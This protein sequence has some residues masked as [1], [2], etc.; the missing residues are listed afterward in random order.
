MSNEDK[1]HKNQSK[2]Y[3]VFD[4]ILAG[5]VFV[6]S[7][8]SGAAIATNNAN[9]VTNSSNEE[10]AKWTRVVGRWTRGLVIVGIITTAVL[11]VQAVILGNQFREM[12]I[13]QRPWVQPS[14]KGF[15]QIKITESS[16]S[17]GVKIELVNTGKSPAFYVFNI[18]EVK[19]GN[20]NLIQEHDKFCHEVELAGASSKNPLV[21]F[22]NKSTQLI[23]EYSTASRDEL[24]VNPNPKS[25]PAGEPFLAPEMLG[26]IVYRAQDE[27]A[28]HHT[29]YSWS[30]LW[31]KGDIPTGIPNSPGVIPGNQLIRM[32][33]DGLLS[34]GRNYAD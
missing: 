26:C 30:I 19:K 29:W 21:L 15:E 9:E 12:Q 16:V 10:I 11:G 1:N 32:G 20:G 5:S 24:T 17:V 4:L 6:A 7:V 14:F 33:G 31:L 28:F 23:I 22:P 25:I 34:P 13:E 2:R 18:Q 3:R 8:I 27:N